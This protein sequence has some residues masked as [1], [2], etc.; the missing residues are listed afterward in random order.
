MR[1]AP[2]NHMLMKEGLFSFMDKGPEPS[3]E[4]RQSNFMHKALGQ[5]CGVQSPNES[6]RENNLNVLKKKSKCG[7]KQTPNKKMHIYNKESLLLFSC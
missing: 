4:E 2:P 5:G 7:F 6:H 3:P 1:E